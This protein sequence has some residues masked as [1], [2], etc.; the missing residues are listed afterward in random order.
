MKNE[1]W[2][3]RIKRVIKERDGSF[4]L[5]IFVIFFTFLTIFLW[6]TNLKASFIENK[7]NSQKIIEI[8]ETKKEDLNESIDNLMIALD[9][10]DKKN[11]TTTIEIS[12]SS[13]ISTSTDDVSVEISKNELEEVKQKLNDKIN[14]LNTTSSSSIPILS[15]ELDDSEQ[16]INELKNKIA[17]LEEKLNEK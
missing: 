5:M 6:V 10:L 11:N 13:P 16:E 14:E 9:N 17:E 1:K 3:E 4:Y 7:K 2:L 8:D 12:T 15:Q